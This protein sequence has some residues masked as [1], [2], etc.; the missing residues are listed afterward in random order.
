[1]K[2]TV[3]ANRVGT[4]YLLKTL[5]AGFGMNYRMELYDQDGTTLL[6]TGYSD[7]RSS[8]AR[9]QWQ[10]PASGTYYLRL[11]PNSGS[12]GYCDAKYELMVDAREMFL[13]L[14]RR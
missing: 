1:V 6:Q 10:A 9:Q 14:V 4:G 13:P 11:V 5:T 7:Y 8:L 2:F 3:P 12:S